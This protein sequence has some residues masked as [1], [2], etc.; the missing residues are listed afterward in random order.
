MRANSGPVLQ[1]GFF[2]ILDRSAVSEAGTDGRQRKRKGRGTKEA[3]P[4]G[5]GLKYNPSYKEGKRRGIIS[6][7]AISQEIE[8]SRS[9]MGK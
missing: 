4:S 1:S 8:L 5:H 2:V 6:E 3:T 9:S 7:I